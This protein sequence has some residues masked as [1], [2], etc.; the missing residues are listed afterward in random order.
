MRL[1][2]DQV[3]LDA[4]LA[5]AGRAA[6]S[7]GAQWGAPT[8]TLRNIGGR[9]TATGSDPDLTIETA[10]TGDGDD[11]TLALPARLAANIVKA[12]SGTVTIDANENTATLTAGRSK[13][14]L[15]LPLRSD[16][17]P[18]S[19]DAEAITLDAQS[20]TEGLRQV[21][22]A[23]LTDGSR[24][25]QLTG[26]LFEPR[27]GSLR[28]VATDS[29]RMAVRD[30]AGMSATDEAVII[31]ARALGEVVRLVGDDADAVVTF[32]RTPTAASFATGAT[33]VTTR[34]LAG[35]FPDYGR[36]IPDE[37]P[38][39]FTTSRD[40]FVAALKRVRVVAAVGKDAAT[41]PVRFS[42]ATGATLRVTTAET[43]N[44]EDYLDGKFVGE[45]VSEIGFQ[46]RFLLDALD[47]ITCEEVELN[48]SIGGKPAV[49]RGVGDEE[50]SVVVMPVRV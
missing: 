9:V 13:F 35:P 34:V 48:L 17:E 33:R 19:V 22:P 14:D 5:I 7:G 8:L 45:M 43:G 10:F 47:A 36:L 12:L 46:A 21:V 32:A 25:P 50:L 29:Y 37:F 2:A 31:P 49:L 4:A 23:A 11:G 26:V 15:R 38:A 6:T 3:T 44:A 42:F 24:S 28:L 30:I 20:L 16:L 40:E 27:D 1:T 39:T 18:P 41:T